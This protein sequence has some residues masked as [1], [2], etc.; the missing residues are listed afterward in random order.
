MQACRLPGIEELVMLVEERAAERSPAER[1]RAA[2]EVGHELTDMGDGLIG[3]FVGEARDAGLSWT[4]IGQLFGTSKQAVQQRFGPTHTEPGAWPGRWSA[5]ARDALDRSGDEALVLG[6]DYIGTEHALLALA[7][8]NRGIAAEVLSDL[9]VT[10]ERILATTCIRPTPHVHD[11]GECRSVM[12]RYKQALEHAR[13]V[14]DGFGVSV[15]D[16]Q[17]LLAG[18]VAVPD[19][20]AVEILRRLK[21]RPDDVRAGLARRLEVDPRRLGGAT[22]RRRRLL[23]ATR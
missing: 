11:P 4:E 7:S 18:I 13:R 16:T 15:A 20:M 12:P 9:G 17:H 8:A 6:H 23:H 2:I 21:V 14:A 19:S 1:L 10:R 3:R 5:A 22:R